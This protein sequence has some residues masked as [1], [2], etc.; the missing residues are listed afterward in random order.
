MPAPEALLKAQQ[1]AQSK[2]A[3]TVGSSVEPCPLKA[4]TWLAIEL[5][6]EDGS[7]IADEPYLV[8]LPDGRQVEGRLNA[9][10]TATIEGINGEE[11][12]VSFPNLDAGA[13]EPAAKT[14]AL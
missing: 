11:C 14:G 3:A 12:L 13:W 8:K 5:L 1:G 9:R 4:K 7:P 10:G 2:G 6:G